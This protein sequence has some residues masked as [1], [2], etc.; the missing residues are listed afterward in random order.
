RGRRRHVPPQ[1]M[2]LS[3]DLL[4]PDKSLDSFPP[5]NASAAK[6][7]QGKPCDVHSVG[8]KAGV[9]CYSAHYPSIFVMNFALNHAVSKSAVVLSWRNLRPK[10]RRRTITSAGHSQRT[11]DLAAGK[12]VERLACGS[13]Q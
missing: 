4:A 6:H 11:K 13:L 7:L 8:E 5:E 9:S 3:A 10:L 2:P 1:G 12:A